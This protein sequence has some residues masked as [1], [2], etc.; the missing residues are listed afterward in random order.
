M[1]PTTSPA[2]SSLISDN[3]TERSFSDTER[4][5]ARA[6]RAGSAESEVHNGWELDWIEDHKLDEASTRYYKLKFKGYPM[7][8]WQPEDNVDALELVR[9]YWE[10]RDQGLPAC[11]QAQQDLLKEIAERPDSEDSDNDGQP[12]LR[13]RVKCHK[14]LKPRPWAGPRQD[15][16]ADLAHS[17]SSTSG[18]EDDDEDRAPMSFQLITPTQFSL[19]PGYRL[20]S[21]TSTTYTYLAKNPE[22]K[23]L[24]KLIS[25]EK[26]PDNTAADHCRRT[27]IRKLWRVSPFVKNL[28]EYVKPYSYIYR[29]PERAGKVR[30]LLGKMKQRESNQPATPSGRKGKIKLILTSSTRSQV[31]ENVA[32]DEGES[33]CGSRVSD[34]NSTTPLTSPNAQTEPPPK[35]MPPTHLV[36]NARPGGPAQ[37]AKKTVEQNISPR[38]RQPERQVLDPEAQER[39]FIQANPGLKRKFIAPSPLTPSPSQSSAQYVLQLGHRHVKKSCLRRKSVI[40]MRGGEAYGEGPAGPTT[41]PYERLGYVSVSRSVILDANLCVQFVRSPS[42]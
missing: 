8:E 38:P 20:P 34:P 9:C 29:N 22:I 24:L 31:R 5:V 19:L 13:D 14:Q 32:L 33:F 15:A 11:I 1:T 3:E 41:P 2:P 30:N 39:I 6:G 4:F 7:A 27:V 17:D 25:L 12:A 23:Q 26:D 16:D 37:R 42:I 21:G 36:Q 35:M 40:F 10:H 18:E 28:E